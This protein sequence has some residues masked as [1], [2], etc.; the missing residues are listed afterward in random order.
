MALPMPQVAAHSGTERTATP[1][2]VREPSAAPVRRICLIRQWHFPL[3]IRASREL[4][5]LCQAGHEVHVVCVRRAG[6]PWREQLGRLTIYRLPPRRGPRTQRRLLCEYGAFVI[7]AGAL[8]TALHLRCGFDLIQV[9]STPDVAVFAALV[10][11]LLGVPV[12]LDLHEPMPEFYATKFKT[13]L[14]HPVVRAVARFE[15]ASIRFAT[16]AITCTEQMR[17]AFICR[18]A[19]DT[20]LA[21]IL[22]GSDEATFDAARFPPRLREPARFVL[23]SHG[24]VEEHYGLDTAIRAVA[25]AKHDVP[26]LRLEI[27]GT[28]SY[29]DEL[30]F[31][32]AELGVLDNVYFSG[33]FVPV[34]AL[35]EAIA[36]ADAGIVAMKRDAFRDLTLCNKM[37]DFISMRTPVIVSRTAPVESYYG[38][39]SFLM[40]AS[41][42]EVE[43][44][45]AIR[46]LHADPNLG[47]RLAARAAQV[48]E[49]YRWH[50]QRAA[51]LGIVNG[52]ING[53]RAQR[54]RWLRWHLAASPV[55]GSLGDPSH[56][57]RDADHHRT[58]G[59]VPG[60]N[61]AGR[62]ERPLTDGDAP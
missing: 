11:R 15:Q 41:D 34:D 25:L 54:V 32:A 9:N 27:Y 47:V 59:H 18:G 31:L 28:G 38:E 62:H 12:L 46:D 37:Y 58:S 61:G 49:P 17:H 53:G 60:D 1:S 50:R 22:N 57:G 24:S 21:V 43:L 8:V 19:P 10:P 14:D 5:A 7:A 44:A 40:F 4:D 13:D 16:A 23:V 48:N 52:L 39:S 20:K 51:Y 6:E 36:R 29:L 2:I 33:A 26:G 3:D 30:R 42:N 45:Q 55:G 35:V 56:T